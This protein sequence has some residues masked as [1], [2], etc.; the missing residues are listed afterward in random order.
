[1]LYYSILILE[2]PSHTNLQ[3][4]SSEIWCLQPIIYI[5]FHIHHPVDKVFCFPFV[6]FLF[7]HSL[8]FSLL[9]YNI[10]RLTM[11]TNPMKSPKYHSVFLKM[12]LFKKNVWN[13]S[14]SMS[15]KTAFLNKRT[16]CWCLLGQGWQRWKTLT[17]ISFWLHGKP[18]VFLVF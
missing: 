10:G 3:C 9:M 1:M 7:F 17:S 16:R 6:F 15:K 12:Y 5:I 4:C 18:F 13:W 8:K 2:R 11:S 14:F